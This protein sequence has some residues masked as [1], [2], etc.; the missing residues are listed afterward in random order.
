MEEKQMPTRM[1]HIGLSVILWTLGLSLVFFIPFLPLGLVES[2]GIILTLGA[3][4]GILL[5]LIDSISSG[6]F[7]FPRSKSWLILLVMILVAAITSFFVPNPANSFIGNGFQFGTIATLTIGFI[8]FFLISVWGRNVNFTKHI[9]KTFFIAGCIIILF[10]TLQLLFNLVGR[11]PKFFVSL[12]N[13][14]LVGSYNDLA[15]FL[16]IFISLIAVG[17]E[18]RFFGKFMKVIAVLMLTLS[19]AFLVILNYTFVWYLVGIAGLCLFISALMP[20]LL[21]KD[22]HMETAKRKGFSFVSFILMVVA[23]VAIVGAKDVGKLVAGKPFYFSNNNVRPSLVASIA[24]MGK[25]YQHNPV[26][27]AGINRYNQAWEA[28]KSKIFGGRLMTTPFW[29]ATFSSSVGMFFTL[30]TTLGILGALLFLWFLG[31]IFFKKILGLFAKERNG[32]FRPKD[33]MT[34]SLI[35]FYAII[36]FLLDSPNVVFFILIF[37]FFGMLVSYLSTVDGLPQKSFSFV[38]DSR[39]SFFSILSVLVCAMFVLL[40]SFGIAKAQYAQ[41]LVNRS[42]FLPVSKEGAAKAKSLVTRAFNISKLDSHARALTAVNILNVA[43]LINDKSQSEESLRS[44]VKDEVTQAVENA[45]TAIRIDPKNYQNYSNFLKVQESLIELGGTD[46]YDS[47][48]DVGNQAL[49]YSP[50]NLEIILRQAKIATFTKNYDQAYEFINKI[51]A[52]NPSFIDA[53][54]LRSQIALSQGDSAKALSEI[55]E[56]EKKYPGDINLLYQKGLLY[57]SQGSYSLAAETFER[58]VRLSPQSMD[59]YSYLATSYE[60]LGQ[61]DAVLKTLETARN[62]VNDKS[63]FDALIE[64]VRNGGSLVAEDLTTKQDS[65]KAKTETTAK[66]TV[67]TAPEKSTR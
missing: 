25:T 61:R 54:L 1:A 6:R 4:V 43:Y 13:T 3:A 58:V 67:K 11:F 44:L 41:Y 15:I 66:T 42:Q 10:S 14:N 12:G 37:A 34:Y 8:Y 56:A 49:I 29:N 46:V 53:Y 9:I 20:R 55:T 2:K 7:L 17:I 47:A 57:F 63:S 31:I 39:Y 48:I 28:N 35:S 51:L 30:L 40:S 64:K 38:H 36:V 33:L 5:W 65:E 59:A 62:Y 16:G 32:K 60:K 21:P 22:A 24:V 52:I 27:G 45:K 50:N 19:L 23:F 18:N 26:I